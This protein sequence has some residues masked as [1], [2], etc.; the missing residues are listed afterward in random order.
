MFV[1]KRSFSEL[2]AI[3]ENIGKEKKMKFSFF[4]IKDIHCQQVLTFLWSPIEWLTFC[5]NLSICYYFLWKKTEFPFFEFPY[6]RVL[7]SCR[8]THWHHVRFELRVLGGVE[9]TSIALACLPE[10]KDWHCFPV[11]LKLANTPPPME[12]KPGVLNFLLPKGFFFN[13]RILRFAV[14][15]SHDNG[16][17]M[18][19]RKCSI[20]SVCTRKAKGEGHNKS[21]G[22]GRKWN[23]ND[24]PFHDRKTVSVV[25][26]NSRDYLRI[27][28]FCADTTFSLLFAFIYFLPTGFGVVFCAKSVLCSW[29]Q[30]SEPAY[31]DSS[32][33]YDF[34]LCR[35]SEGVSHVFAE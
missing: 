12:N 34:L 5:Q 33:Q 18:R 19:E 4:S 25:L 7:P 10:R 31:R 23:E 21:S 32:C 29:C 6:L 9:S 2:S 26:S 28:S 27:I 35:E 30:A 14:W 1:W 13:P 20:S 3:P 11:F 15:C 16:S 8:P 24:I 22:A 17:C